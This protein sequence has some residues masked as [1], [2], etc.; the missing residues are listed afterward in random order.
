MLFRSEEGGPL[1]Y[2][3]V[4]GPTGMTIDST[5][6]LTWTPVAAD[7][8]SHPVEATATDPSGQAARLSFSVEVLAVND[9]PKINAQSP[10]EAQV[11]NPTRGT[12]S[13]AVSVSD[14]EGDALSF[15]WLVNGAVQAD[16][17]DSSFS[18]APPATQ[19][20]SITALI[21]DASDTTRFTW[22][23]D[24]RQI[25]RLGLEIGRAHV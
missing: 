21:A 4:Q 15:S 12:V 11:L 9:A 3:L 22:Q 2:A 25:A 7:I 23:L 18:Y 20:D 16:A 8:G 5:G 17:S 24:S 10:S 13:F 6:V 19:I 1:T 14:E